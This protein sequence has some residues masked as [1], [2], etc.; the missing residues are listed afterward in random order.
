MSPTEWILGDAADLGDD[1]ENDD[2]GDT[3]AGVA[4]GDIVDAVD[5]AGDGLL[6]AAADGASSGA[7][8]HPP[9]PKLHPLGEDLRWVGIGLVP[10]IELE[11]DPF[12]QAVYSLG[13]ASIV[14]C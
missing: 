9:L 2:L 14:H 10:Y 6:V 5:V 3:A 8:F 11:R 7:V 4:T 13:P 12:R 1:I